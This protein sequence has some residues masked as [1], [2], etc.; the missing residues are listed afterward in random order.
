MMQCKIVDEVTAFVFRKIVAPSELLLFSQNE[1]SDAGLQLPEGA[2]EIGES[3][4]DGVLRI[5]AEVC[6]CRG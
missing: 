3:I 5:L 6:A 4:E 1:Q 2:V